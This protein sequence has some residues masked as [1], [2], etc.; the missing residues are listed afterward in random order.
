VPALYY[1]KNE[2]VQFYVGKF[3]LA[4]LLAYVFFNS[5][6]TSFN[7]G[8]QNMDVVQQP[9]LLYYVEQARLQPNSSA[10]APLQWLQSQVVLLYF[11]LKPIVIATCIYLVLSEIALALSI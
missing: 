5:G 4:L 10:T 6:G 2:S 8:G 9:R 11:L 1:W 7:V 3:I